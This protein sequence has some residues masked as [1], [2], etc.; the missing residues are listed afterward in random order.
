MQAYLPTIQAMFT[1]WY[2]FILNNPLYAGA[3]AAVVWLLTATLYSIRLASVKRSKSASEKAGLE[4]LTAIQKQLELSQEALT[5]TCLK[6]EQAQSATQHESQRALSLEQLIY[7]RNQQIASMIQT[8]ATSFDLGERPLL[9]SEDLQSDLLWQQHNKVTALLIERLRTEQ[10]AK[11]E[12]QQTYQAETA[13]LAEK[14]V[15]LEAL[16]ST[17]DAHTEQ[18]S[19]LEQALAEQKTILQLQNQAQQ[20]LSDTLKKHQPAMIRPAEPA[21][22]KPAPALEISPTPLEVPSSQP[23]TVSVDTDEP[24]AA[25]TWQDPSALT[26]SISSTP[27]AINPQPVINEE[28]YVSLDTEQQPVIAAKGSL[29]KLKNLFGKKQESVKTEPQWTNKQ[30]DEKETLISSPEATEQQPDNKVVKTQG[31]LKGFYN[32]FKSKE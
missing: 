32:K 28:S 27:P 21:A 29:G 23:E 2:L 31:K 3:L 9:A 18:L 15:L 17:L 24:Y 16:H 4:K 12:L 10:Q 13:K 11:I 5:E 30:P 6:I 26:E 25:A 1:E 8:L 20:D 7:Q 14:D 22:I 19:K